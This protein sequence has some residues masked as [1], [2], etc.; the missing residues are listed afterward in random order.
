M[1]C[2]ELDGRLDD[3]IDGVLE[4]DA[5]TGVE[6]HLRGCA[7]CREHERQ[8]R[9]LLAHAAALPRS[10]SPA[11]D[12]WPG[13]E[14]RLAAGGWRGT[15][16]SW[17]GPL[18]LAAA[19]AVLVALGA[20]FLA[21]RGP[22]GVETAQIP[23]ARVERVSTPA[24]VS[25]PVLAEA[26]RNYEEAANDLLAKL[27]ERA[28]RLPAAE[29]AR[30]Q[31]NLQVIDRALAEVRQAIAKDPASPELNRMLVSTHRKKVDVL[32]RVVRL[33]TVL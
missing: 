12:L 29:F 4:R 1:T 31:E 8:L 24:G 28:D 15:V 32:R 9:E 7:E 26:E 20:A 25:D 21:E 13:I 5:A 10:V 33:S 30:V 6:E 23:G 22:S 17:R 14:A 2:Q 11:R 19:A 16:A 27:Q 3:W 18:V